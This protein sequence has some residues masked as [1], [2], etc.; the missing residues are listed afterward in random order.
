[1][2][3]SR[4]LNTILAT[5]SAEALW[6]MHVRL[7]AEYG[8]DR[9]LY[10]HAC[11][12]EPRA[13]CDPDDIVMF[14]HLGASGIETSASDGAAT[15][16]LWAMNT[17]G[18]HSWSA[19]AARAE[20]GRSSTSERA[21]NDFRNAA[22]MRAGYTISFP[23]MPRRTKGAIALDAGRHMTQHQV[24]RLWNSCGE[25]ILLLNNLLHLRLASLPCAPSNRLLTA[26]QRE[27]LEWI[28]QGKTTQDAAVL[29]SLMPP[30][31]EKHLRLAREV[32][33]AET[34]T[35]AVLKAAS[36]N[37]IFRKWRETS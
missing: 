35:Q 6:A 22:Q 37:Q 8:F 34:T 3:P 20:A 5:D 9:L 28:G 31:V 10:G 7:M 21:F 17:E 27:A 18:A 4:T 2:I 1:M 25:D 14:S 12:M 24:N 15:M 29:M 23:W 30:T 19:M 32:L 36:Q 13:L 11:L 16:L 33:N 26:R